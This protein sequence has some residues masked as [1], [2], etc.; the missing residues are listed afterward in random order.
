MSQRTRTLL[1]ASKVAVV[2]LITAMLFI[3]VINAM[4]NPVDT[5]T[6]RYSAEF[7]DASRLHVNG[8][9]RMKGMRIGKVEAVELDKASDGTPVAHVEF[10]MDEKF[11][12]TDSTELAI[13]YQSLTGVRYLDVAQNGGA[14]SAGPDDLREP[15]DAVVRHHS[16]VQRITAGAVH[17]EHR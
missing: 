13:K 12:L 16:A 14:R 3:L 5:A 1:T 4:R 15:D 2:E 17:D 10:S 11:T 7:T 8:D 9:V 6:N